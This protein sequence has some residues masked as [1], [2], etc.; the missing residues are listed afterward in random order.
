MS[1]TGATTNTNTRVASTAPPSETAQG[2]YDLATWGA[3]NIANYVGVA[4]STTIVS[5]ANFASGTVTDGWSTKFVVVP[6]PDA[7]ALAAVGVASALGIS[8]RRRKTRPN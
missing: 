8:W 3:A 4:K 1:A 5:S 2:Y 6:E 7:V